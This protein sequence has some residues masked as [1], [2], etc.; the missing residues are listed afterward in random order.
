MTKII[1][2]DVDGVIL[3]YNKSWPAVWKAAF[4]EELTSQKVAY[5]AYNEFGTGHLP[6]DRYALFKQHFAHEAWSSMP[7]LDG[8]KEACQ[9][10]DGAGYA[11]VA[12]TSMPPLYETARAI[13]LIKRHGVPLVNVIATG[14]SGGDN[15]KLRYIEELDPVAFVDDLV[16]NFDGVPTAVHCALIEP[17]FYDSPNLQ[18]DHARVDS[19]HLNL[20]AFAKWWL[21]Q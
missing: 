6:P 11:L 4:N 13:N 14:R 17:G 7:L 9:L 12:V 21:S 18:A 1:A 3:N 15:P 8:A 10:L 5:H 16:S 19:T 2:L 20:L